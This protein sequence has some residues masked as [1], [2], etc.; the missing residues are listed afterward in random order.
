MGQRHQ[1]FVIARVAARYRC[2]A[3]VHHQWLYG[4]TALR[5]CRD[6]LKNFSDPRNRWALEEE[7]QMAESF[8][9]SFWHLGEDQNLWRDDIQVPFPFVMTCLILGAS[10]NAEDGYFHRV[11]IE[12][13]H[14]PYNG[15][16]NNNGKCTLA[17]PAPLPTT[18][19]RNHYH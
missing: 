9:D 3:A 11:H 19:H 17:N 1:L 12:P 5:R 18:S 7:L 2:L 14:L 10:F 8:D 4:N 15:G 13:F 16:D 6:I